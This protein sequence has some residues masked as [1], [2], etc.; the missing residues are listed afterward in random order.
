MVD[1]VGTTDV[2]V[3][4]STREPVDETGGDVVVT[5]ET[6]IEQPNTKSSDAAQICRVLT[7]RE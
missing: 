5:E 7:S 3:P 1:G 2:V 6:G 4:T